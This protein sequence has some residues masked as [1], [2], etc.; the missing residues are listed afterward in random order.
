MIRNILKWK[1][2]VLNKLKTISGLKKI[3]TTQ[4]SGSTAL[5]ITALNF[6]RG[7]ILII[8]TGYYSN[9]LYNLAKYA[10]RTHKYIKKKVEK[11]NWLKI[12]KYKKVD[13]VWAC[14][15]ETSKGL[16]IPIKEL[17]LF[18]KKN[19]AKLALDATAS[20]GLEKIMD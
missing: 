9:R 11:L 14:V 13:W 1:K 12:S 8:D 19:N 17:K 10:M 7:K 16:T 6:L 5:E 4:G 2:K 15:T 18:S 3:V 20:I